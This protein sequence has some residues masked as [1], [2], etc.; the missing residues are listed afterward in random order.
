M[1]ECE[2]CYVPLTNG[3]FAFVDR[4]D[5]DEIMIFKWYKEKIGN[6]WYAISKSHQKD[7]YRLYMHRALM[8]LQKGD[9][10]KVDHINGN[11]LDNRRHN[12]RITTQSDNIANQ[13]KQIRNTSG[14]IGVSYNKNARKYQS[15]ITIDRKRIH[16]GYFFDPETAAVLYDVAVN[17]LR[18]SQC[19]KNFYK[20]ERYERVQR[21]LALPR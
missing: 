4:Q 3:G 9:R 10:K 19:R 11:G 18:G 7:N 21:L 12:L 8:R 5:Y 13:K 6:T 2:G 20:G 1:R 15:Y 14:Y 16:L 17:K